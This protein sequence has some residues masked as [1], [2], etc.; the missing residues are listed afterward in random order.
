MSTEA[1]QSAVRG[2]EHVFYRAIDRLRELAT[3]ETENEV[4]DLTT[5]L[6]E[7]L[8]LLACT[9]R[10]IDGRTTREIYKAFGAPGDFGYEKPIGQA[11]DALYRAPVPASG[12][13]GGGT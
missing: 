9:R 12:D 7:A 3:E 10:L 1:L 13:S 4:Y 2:R 5:Q 8:F 11:L 6:K